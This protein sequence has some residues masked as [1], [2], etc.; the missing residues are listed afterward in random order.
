MSTFKVI[1]S[2]IIGL[3]NNDNSLTFISGFFSAIAVAII[4]NNEIIDTM[5][6]NLSM[7]DFSMIVTLEGWGFIFYALFVMVNFI[8]GIQAAKYEN[9]KRKHPRKSWLKCGKL[10]RTMWKTFGTLLLT[11]MIASLALLLSIMEF[12]TAFWAA[13]WFLI[14]FWLLASG[15]EFYSI[16]ENIERRTGIKPRIFAFW[17]KILAAIEGKFLT[18]IDDVSFP[19]ISNKQNEDDPV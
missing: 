14:V 13:V 6:D 17:D 9:S 15:Y 4:K 11:A 18:K 16:G 7:K 19:S 12:R 10:Y 1:S 2:Y 3:F 8:T 5:S